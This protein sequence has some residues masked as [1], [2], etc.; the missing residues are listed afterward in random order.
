MQIPNTQLGKT[1]VTT[2][3]KKLTTGKNV[4]IVSIIV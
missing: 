4:F 3:F 1:S 2:Q